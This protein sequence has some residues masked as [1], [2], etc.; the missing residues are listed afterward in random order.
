MQVSRAKID[1]EIKDNSLSRKFP[2]YGVGKPCRCYV[3]DKIHFPSGI[4]TTSPEES[5]FFNGFEKPYNVF[6]KK[7]GLFHPGIRFLMEQLPG[8]Q[9]V[10][11]NYDFR[12][13]NPIVSA[14]DTPVKIN[15]S[16]C[17]RTEGFTK[18][19][20]FDMFGWLASRHRKAPAPLR[21]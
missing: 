10:A 15:A 1:W 18:R 19:K 8:V 4:F 5:L 9:H 11:G 3:S 6:V 2:E 12:F 7:I 14:E 13:H 21:M 17:A 20:P 16:G